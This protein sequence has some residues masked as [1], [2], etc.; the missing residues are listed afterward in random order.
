MRCDWPYSL[1]PLR[2]RYSYA[3]SSAKRSFGPC[4]QSQRRLGALATKLGEISALAA[5]IGE[6]RAP[7]ARRLAPPA[8]GGYAF[9][10]RT[11]NGS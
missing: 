1:K 11:T 4:G 9:V 10:N 6:L 5:D 8:G 3:F 7:E 2:R